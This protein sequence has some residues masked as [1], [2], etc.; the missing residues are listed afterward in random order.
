MGIPIEGESIKSTGE[1]DLAV[2][3]LFYEKLNQTLECIRSFLPSGVNIYVLNNG[4]SLSSRQALERFCN[5]YKQ[6][7]IFDSDVNLGVGVGR[8]YLIAHTGEEWLLFVDNDIVVKTP[9]WLQRFT[10]YVSMYDDIEVFIPKL[11]NVQERYYSPC[12]PLR[13]VG[14]TVIRVGEIVNGWTNKFHGGASIINRKLF[15]RLGLYDDK[16]FVGFEDVELCIRGVRLGTPVNARHMHDIVL[17]HDHRQSKE[18]EDRETLLVRYDVNQIKA[19][20]NRITEKHNL[21][22]EGEWEIWAVDAI[23]KMSK[24]DNTFKKD[25]NS[26]VPNQA[27]KILGHSTEMAVSFA[28]FVLPN[29]VKRILK[30]RLHLTNRPTPHSCS[31]YMTDRCNF[32]SPGCYKNLIGVKHSKEMTLATVQKLLSLYPSLNAFTVAGLGE[33]TLCSDFVDIIN[34][35]KK[36]GKFVGVITNDTNLNKLFELAYE[37]NYISINLNGYDNDNY[38]TTGISA[39]NRVLKTFST[40]KVRYKNVGFSYTL[41]RANYRDL[42]KILLLCDELKPEFLHLTNYLV[43]DPT[44]TR[45]VQKIITVKDTEIID[46]IDEICVGRDYIKVKPVY[47]DFENPKFNCR[48]YDYVITVDGEGNIGGCQRQVSPDASFGNIFT[49]KDPYN[50][51]KMRKLGEHM[52]KKSYP[53]KE[54]RFCFEN[55]AS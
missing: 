4:S 8:N 5:N 3:I 10:R 52:H 53:H 39:F 51:L 28:S 50:S 49:D 29:P 19:S 40:L 34:F 6:I 38:F 32:K 46:Y 14:D 22:L 54:C 20:L 47:V 30:K 41:N 17:A 18:R 36:N 16:L 1:V 12:L 31:L 33:P 13:I 23:E 11:Y 21:V 35:L 48:S 7:K 37:P 43:H 2:C 24:N 55:W 26:W 25:W 42:D 44:V 45:E 27:K 9:D 15:N